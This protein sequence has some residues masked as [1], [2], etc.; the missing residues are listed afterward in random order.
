MKIKTKNLELVDLRVYR[1]ELGVEVDENMPKAIVI[2][3]EVDG[4]YYNIVSPDETYPIM[5]R[6]PYS[7]YTKFN[8]EF[9]TKLSVINKEQ[10][11][12]KGICGIIINNDFI[13]QIKQKEL[14]DEK[15]LEDRILKSDIYFKD[16]IR[17]IE[18][19]VNNS[20][21]KRKYLKI[22]YNDWDKNCHYNSVVTNLK[23]EDKKMLENKQIQLGNKKIKKI[24]NVSIVKK[25]N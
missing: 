16:R 12:E 18:Q 6:I 19:R 10:I 7:S 3:N 17:I 22:A 9:G 2:K 1:K 20:R 25:Q 4:L 11:K 24:S 14:I 13:E 21:R 15:D 8:T 23:D 5:K